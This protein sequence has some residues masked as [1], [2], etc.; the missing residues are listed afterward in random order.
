K[1][2][3]ICCWEEQKN[4]KISPEKLDEWI[5]NSVIEIVINIGEAPFLVHLYS[6]ATTTNL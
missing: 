4:K 6:P 5:S 3:R 2:E 1:E